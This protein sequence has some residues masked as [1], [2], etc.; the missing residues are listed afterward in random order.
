MALTRPSAR[1]FGDGVVALVA[2]LEQPGA[3][4]HGGD[5]VAVAEGEGEGEGVSEGSSVLLGLGG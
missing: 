3:E 4:P 1:N 2:V 5:A